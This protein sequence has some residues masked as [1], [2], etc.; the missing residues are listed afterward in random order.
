MKT[1]RLKKVTFPDSGEV[2]YIPNISLAGQSLRVQR[3][4]PRPKPPMQQVDYGNGN[5]KWE[6]NY[7]HPDYRIQLQEWQK[8]L[9]MATQDA[10]L[11]RLYRMKLSEDQETDITEWKTANP[12]LY[13]ETDT[14]TAIWFEE[15]AILTENDFGALIDA[16][17]GVSEEV[18]DAIQ[19]D[20]QGDAE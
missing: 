6:S 4:Y 2:A 7:A 12:D 20:F 15:I 1:A 3:K 17:G 10:A 16:L 19:D 5:M 8:F 9:G 13:D 14:D 11:K 18:V